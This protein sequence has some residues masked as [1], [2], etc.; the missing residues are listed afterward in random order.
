MNGGHV[1]VIRE[2][3]LSASVVF[4]HKGAGAARFCNTA[5]CVRDS[6]DVFDSFNRLYI[7]APVWVG[8]NSNTFVHWAAI[9]CS[10]PITRVPWNAAGWE[11]W[12]WAGIEGELCKVSGVA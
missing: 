6:V 5:D 7:P 11:N 12:R 1:T 2:I 3:Q 10:V 8:V 9:R 4:Q